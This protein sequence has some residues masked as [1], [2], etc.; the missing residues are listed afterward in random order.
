MKKCELKIDND[1]LLSFCPDQ[2]YPALKLVRSL[3]FHHHRLSLRKN[4][5]CVSARR[6]LE[7]HPF[8]VRHEQNWGR[9]LLPQ[10]AVLPR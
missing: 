2:I 4:F 9:V 7:G 1:Q 6:R 5:L 10:A 3:T 8:Q